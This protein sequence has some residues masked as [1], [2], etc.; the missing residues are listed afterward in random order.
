MSESNSLVSGMAPGSVED[1][2]DNPL[3]IENCPIPGHL[4]PILKVKD[5][6]GHKLINLRNPYDS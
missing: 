3:M 6:Y 2:D 5:V 1:V 4:Y